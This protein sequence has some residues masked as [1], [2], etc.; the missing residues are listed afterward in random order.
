[1]VV[2]FRKKATMP[3]L[4]DPAAPSMPRPVMVQLTYVSTR[5]THL[6]DD[7][8]VEMAIQA[9]VAN[10]QSE[11]TGCLWFGPRRFFQVLEGEQDRIDRLYRKIKLDTRHTDVRL[12]RYSALD[13]QQFARWSL[14]HVA[15]DEDATI[16][17]LIVDYA[18]GESHVP[19]EQQRNGTHLRILDRLR[20]VLG[21]RTDSVA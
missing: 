1:M 15:H 2:V 13:K 5:A 17:K 11:I 19:A 14:A 3:H 10:R 6:L 20:E 9:N 12:L 16:E 4:T 8:V 18:G 21:Q 7:D